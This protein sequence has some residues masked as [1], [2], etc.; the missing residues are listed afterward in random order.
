MILGPYIRL[1]PLD[2]I[3]NPCD[4]RSLYK[5]NTPCAARPYIKFNNPFLLLGSH[6]KFNNPCDARL[7]YK[8]TMECIYGVIILVLIGFR[9][10]P[11]QIKINAGKIV[12]KWCSIHRMFSICEM[13][14]YKKNSDICHH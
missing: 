14:I 1:I 4:T 11:N 7:L 5:V 6:I 10:A 3:N 2:L 8:C 13:F 9:L 12:C